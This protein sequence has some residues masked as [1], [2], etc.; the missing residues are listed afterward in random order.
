MKNSQ[1]QS[2][3]ILRLSAIGDVCHALATVQAIQKK[4]PNAQITWV[5]GKIE[6]ALLKDL[7]GINFVVFDKKQGWRAYLALKKQLPQ[8]FDVL[9]HMQ[10]ALRANLA[11]LCIKARRKIGFAKPLCKELHSWVVSEH[12]Q[13]PETPHVLEG[14]ACFARAIGVEVLPPSWSFEVDEQ[15]HQWAAQQIKQGQKTLLIAAA[16]SKA[17]RNWTV[18]G[19]AA[20]ADHA[21]SKGFQV[22]LTGGP[23]ASEKKLSEN[24]AQK[25][26]Q[27]LTNLTGQSNLSQLMALIAAADIVLAP[28]TGPAHMATTQNTPVIGLYAHSNPART[29]PYLSLPYVVSVYPE[30][31]A[32][33]YQKDP[34][35]L[36]W[37]T[38]AK[39]D[40][41]MDKIQIKQVIEMFDK[42]LAEKNLDDK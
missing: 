25:A 2:I 38:R 16:A 31:I 6:Y 3:C 15:D 36:K 20:L 23:S 35:E 19:Y 24:I 40:D 7:A 37:G 34:K 1:I 21:V 12:C 22:I 41:L 42:L 29:G 18:A 39:G 17:E 27:P 4:Y 11:A 8:R 26:S 30:V 14:F 13:M 5:I 28:D 9:L 32:Q 10:L 33:Q